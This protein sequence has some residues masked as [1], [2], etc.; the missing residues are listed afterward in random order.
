MNELIITHLFIK[1]KFKA[2]KKAFQKPSQEQLTLLL[3]CE[4]SGSCFTKCSTAFTCLLF[5]VGQVKCIVFII[6]SSSVTS[7]NT[8]RHKESA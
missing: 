6:K 8:E 5:G 2:V 1:L 4:L 7:T 3:L